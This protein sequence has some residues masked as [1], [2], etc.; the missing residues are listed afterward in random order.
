MSDR[1]AHD[2]RPLFPAI[3]GERPPVYLDGPAGTQVPQAVI[4]AVSKSLATAN[5]NTGGSFASSR[6]NDAM[7]ADAHRAAADFLNAD[8]PDE[9]AFGGNMT[10]L[11]MGLSRALARTWSPGDVINVTRL[12][13]EANITPWQLAARDAGASVRFVDIHPDDCT[14]DVDHFRSLLGDRTRL[15]A[16][17]AASNAVGTINPIA[18]MC[19]AAKDAG[20][21][22]FVDA[23]HSAPHVLPD[24]RAIGCDFLACSA[25]KFFGPH[26]GMLYA[27]AESE[28]DLEPYRVRPAPSRSPGRW[29][30]GTQNFASIAG[31]LAAIDYL[32]SLGQGESRRR[33]LE[34]AYERIT[35]HERHVF[36]RLL[37]G[38]GDIPGVRVYG[39]TDSSRMAERCPTLAFTHETLAAGEVASFRGEQ[40]IYAWSGHYYALTLFETL[41]LLP[42]GAVRLGVMHYTSDEDIDRT[43]EAIRSL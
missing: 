10:T 32:A 16:V 5:A 34:S 8:S 14:L 6:R 4:D 25:Y 24:V 23:V 38:L 42:D 35:A 27:R 21:M 36:D 41:G 1:L 3:A 20:A 15:V 12:D 19:Q 40:D 31:T 30:T 7:L 43:L 39:I 17:G 13:H 28:A 2:V 26:V 33:R 22:T 37:R 29:M 18:E 9:V 11:V